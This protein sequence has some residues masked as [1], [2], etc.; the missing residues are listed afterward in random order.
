MTTVNGSARPAIRFG[1]WDS[2]SGDQEGGRAAPRPNPEVVARA[3]RRRFTAGY[4][5]KI[6]ADADAA[7]RAGNLGALLRQEGLYSSLLVTWRRE[8]EAGI[9]KGLTPRKRGPKAK[10][11]PLAGEYQKLQRKNELLAEQLRKAEIVI[12]V[13]KKV[14]ALLGR[15]FPETETL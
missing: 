6:L 9:L 7:K 14:A 1:E 12:D 13:Q 4:K 2:T 15:A 11:D 3:K 10:A 8:R 5:Q